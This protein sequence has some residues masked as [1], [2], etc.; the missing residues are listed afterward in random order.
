MGIVTAIKGL[1]KAYIAHKKTKKADKLYQS[2]RTDKYSGNVTDP[3]TIKLNK[4]LKTAKQVGAGAVGTL[5]A[6]T[7]AGKIK[8]KNKEKKK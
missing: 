8:Q 3:D 6:A 4:Q 5:G 7:I 2:Q 1:G